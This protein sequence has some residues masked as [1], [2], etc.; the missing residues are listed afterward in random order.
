LC[1]I[2][3]PDHRLERA[4]GEDVL[5]VKRFDRVITAAGTLRHRVVSA[6]T[7]FR[8]DEAVARFAYTGS[9]MRF[10]RELA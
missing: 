10:A 1:G 2:S 6:A 8:A 9:Y 7:V 5:L 3:V 4:H